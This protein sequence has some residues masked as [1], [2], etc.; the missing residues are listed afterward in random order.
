MEEILTNQNLID[1]AACYGH[2]C[3]LESVNLRETLNETVTWQQ[4]ELLVPLAQI[5]SR[6]TLTGTLRASKAYT[7]TVQI[8][9]GAW[10]GLEIIVTQD[11]VRGR[12][13][14]PKVYQAAMEQWETRLPNENRTIDGLII[15]S[16]FVD[17]TGEST[18]G[19]TARSLDSGSMAVLDSLDLSGLGEISLSY[20]DGTGTTH[21]IVSEFLPGL[22]TLNVSETSGLEPDLIS[23]HVTIETFNSSG[24]YDSFVLHGNTAL[25]DVH[26]G[27][28]EY[29]DIEGCLNLNI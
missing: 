15:M 13:W 11:M 21:K 22:E 28:P 1:G 9:R 29:L 16:G 10:P 19:I 23:G 4:L 14:N 2:T 27:S 8:L 17:R 7:D 20:T 18:S 25:N 24:S 3:T 12:F 5:S 6:V 26:L